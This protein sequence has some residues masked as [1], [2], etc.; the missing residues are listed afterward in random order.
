VHTPRAGSEI[1]TRGAHEQGT[2]EEEEEEEEEEEKRAALVI[3]TC[4][5]RAMARKS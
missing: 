1:E 2:V 5:V 3:H 4:I